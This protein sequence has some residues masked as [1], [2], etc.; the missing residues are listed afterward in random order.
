VIET[1]GFDEE[2]G[3]RSGAHAGTHL[4]S[5]LAPNAP[6]AQLRSTRILR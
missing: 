1:E 3:S 4:P 6:V 5:I 2:E